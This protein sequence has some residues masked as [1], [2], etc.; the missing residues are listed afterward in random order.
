MGDFSAAG[1]TLPPLHRLTGISDGITLGG[2]D[3]G[4]GS[5]SGSGAGGNAGDGEGRYL[6]NPY[7][8]S[9]KFDARY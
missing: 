6:F 3:G 5:G 8:S 7:A 9:L 4:S 1:L 2:S